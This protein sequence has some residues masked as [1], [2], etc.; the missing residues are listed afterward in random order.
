MLTPSRSHHQNNLFYSD[1]LL[2]LDPNDPLILLSQQIPW[3]D[4]DQ[5]FIQHYDT[6]QGRPAKPIRLMVGLLI[7]K[8]LENLSDEQVVVQFKRN[9]YYQVFC[10]FSEF[11]Q[12]PPCDA[13][14]L[15]HFRKRIGS[16]GVERIFHMSVKLHGN[17]AEEKHVIVDTTVQEKAITY[18][19]DAK[20]AIK[21]INRLNKLA[22]TEGIAQRRT[23]TK[24]VKA[25]RLDLRFFRHVKKRAKARRALKRL[26]TIAKTLIRELERKL[27]EVRLTEYEQSFAFYR[28]VLSQNKDDKDKIYSLHEPQ[29]C[30]IAKGKDHKPY[31]YGSKVSI[32]STAT[33]GVIVGVA[34]HEGNPHDSQ[35]LPSALE[36]AMKNRDKAIA[37]AI[38][39]RGYRGN[40]RIGETEIRL[41]GKAL[42]HDSAYQ[43]QKKRKQCRRRA[44]I[45][46][47][48]GHL[49]SDF[50][51]SRNWL[52]GAMGDEINLYM[53]ACAWNLRK[54]MRNSVLF[55]WLRIIVVRF[56]CLYTKSRHQTAPLS[57]VY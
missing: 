9:P 56:A 44:A 30:C 13:T 16:E 33:H 36:A 3:S 17:K 45:E 37:C 2:Q 31:E 21:I 15:V 52:K 50:R 34:N 11:Q 54:W 57:A 39:D 55:Y 10:G 46:P 28:Q 32:V 20:L 42:K 43:R 51:L 12:K 23:Y 22:K 27:P 25:L 41:P 7:L 49:K 6:T 8:H 19:T 14:E 1:L 47:Q 5:A 53:A 29:V 26:R 38:C 18:P 4:F 48:I 35:T 24:E 40:K